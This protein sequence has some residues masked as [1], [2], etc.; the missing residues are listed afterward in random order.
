MS[1]EQENARRAAAIVAELSAVCAQHGARA[2]YVPGDGIWVVVERL[3][4]VEWRW[5]LVSRAAKVEVKGIGNHST[6]PA[7]SPVEIAEGLTRMSAILADPAFADALAIA[8]TRVS[9]DSARALLR[10][11]QAERAAAAPQ[12]YHGD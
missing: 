11:R 3:V 6:H 8:L 12:K 10:Y 7:V 2:Y 1:I 5:S 9:G 4:V